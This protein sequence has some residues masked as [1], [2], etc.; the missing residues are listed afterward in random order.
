MVKGTPSVWSSSLAGNRIDAD[1]QND[2]AR[3]HLKGIYS[4]DI[5]RLLAISARIPLAH[6]SRL[7]M[8]S[9]RKKAKF[10]LF[11]AMS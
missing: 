11:S 1:I 4:K 3:I 10:S 2:R 5:R 7:S 6:R 9:E 8:T